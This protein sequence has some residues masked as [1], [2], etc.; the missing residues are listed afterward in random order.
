MMLDDEVEDDSRWDGR[1]NVSVTFS[2]MMM[3][4]ES[5][6]TSLQKIWVKKKTLVGCDKGWLSKFNTIGYLKTVTQIQ[7]ESVIENVDF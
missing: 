1:V 2:T 3:M 4:Y 5:G 7:F 6:R